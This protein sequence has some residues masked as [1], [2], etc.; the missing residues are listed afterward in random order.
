MDLLMVVIMFAIPS[1]VLVYKAI[2]AIRRVLNK[3]A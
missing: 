3:N 1:I 2:T